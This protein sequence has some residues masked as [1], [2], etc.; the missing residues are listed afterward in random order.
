M[1]SASQLTDLLLDLKNEQG[2][3]AALAS[4]DS[5]LGK[6]QSQ[7]LWHD[8]AKELSRRESYGKHASITKVRFSHTEDN[9][10]DQAINHFQ[11]VASGAE[12]DRF[13]DGDLLGGVLIE[14]SK[15]KLDLTIDKQLHKLAK[16]LTK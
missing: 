11:P 9:D 1:Y 6:R 15:H 4:V 8:I 10:V 12:L 2:P 16:N 7:Y 5:Y 3:T 13:V 14:D